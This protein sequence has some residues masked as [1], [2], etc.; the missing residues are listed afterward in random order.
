MA[1]SAVCIV[2]VG[3]CSNLNSEDAN[4]FSKMLTAGIKSWDHLANANANTQLHQLLAGN[5]SEQMCNK[6]GD[7]LLEWPGSDQLTI[8]ALLNPSLRTLAEQLATIQPRHPNR[9]IVY[10]GPLSNSSGWQ[11]RDAFVTPGR[12]AHLAG[13]S[14]SIA[15]S[16]NLSIFE[17]ENS[18]EQMLAQFSSSLIDRTVAIS[19]DASNGSMKM[20]PP[21]DASAAGS[22]DCSNRPAVY[23]F[24]EAE[25]PSLCLCVDGYCLV[26]GLGVSNSPSAWRFLAWLVR[27]DALLLTNWSESAGLGALLGHLAGCGG[28]GPKLQ[29]CL[30]PG[31]PPASSA[32]VYDLMRSFNGGN[33]LH[34]QEALS[35]L[36]AKKP[37]E[38]LILYSMVGRGCLNLYCFPVAEQQQ[39]QKTKPAV[40]KSK[41]SAANAANSFISLLVWQPAAKQADTAA[42]WSR[43]LLPGAATDS[44]VLQALDRGDAKSMDCLRSPVYTGPQAAAAAAAPTSKKTSTAPAAASAA[45]K[46][47]I[48]SKAKPTAAAPAVKA[49]AASS[50]SKPT[51]AVASKSSKSPSPAPAATQASTGA[52]KKAPAAASTAKRGVVAPAAAASKPVAKPTAKSAPAVKLAPTKSA[53]TNAAAKPTTAVSRPPAK[54]A[55]TVAAKAPA[56][57]EPKKATS[58]APKAKAEPA[59][60]KAAKAPVKA[61]ETASAPSAA[62]AAATAAKKKAPAKKPPAEVEPVPK[63]EDIVTDKPQDTTDLTDVVEQ[64]TQDIVEVSQEEQ[65]SR[66]IVEAG[67]EEEQ[68]S[69]EILK[70]A[71]VEEQKSHEIPEATDEEDQKSQIFEAADEEDQKSHEILEAA[72][73]E[74][75]KS[76]EILEAA[77][78]EDQK[79]HDIVEADDDEE[80]KSQELADDYNDEKLESNDI[81]ESDEQV[82]KDFTG[83][84][85]A[86]ENH[87][88]N[89]VAQMA[90]DVNEDENLNPNNQ[91]L[92]GLHD[93]SH[94]GLGEFEKDH[95]P[96]IFGN[97]NQKPQDMFGGDAGTPQDVFG[98]ESQKPQ[99]MFG[100]ETQKPQ[101]MFG[102]ESQKPQDM[103][104]DETQKPQDMFGDESQKPQDMFGDESQKPQDMFG[105]ESQTAHVF[106][107]GGNGKNYS[108]AIQTMRPRYHSSQSG[109]GASASDDPVDDDD[110]IGTEEVDNI[111][112]RGPGN[113]MQQQPLEP[114]PKLDTDYLPG[115]DD[116]HRLSAMEDAEA[117]RPVSGEYGFA[118]DSDDNNDDDNDSVKLAPPAIIGKS[119]LDSVDEFGNNDTSGGSLPMPGSANGNGTSS[120]LSDSVLQANAEADSTA[121]VGDDD[122]AGVGMTDSFYRHGNGGAGDL[123]QL[124][125]QPQI[126]PI[127]GWDQPLDFQLRHR[128]PRRSDRHLHR[129]IRPHQP[130]RFIGS[131]WP[132][133]PAAASLTASM[134]NFSDAFELVTTLWLAASRIPAC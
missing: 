47:S 6:S 128:P 40:A 106:S 13:D 98:D 35:S 107:N 11:L 37:T 32:A 50:S 124:Q 112:W 102:D 20:R 31:K 89:D 115:N 72:D 123:D 101:E 92:I 9:R 80:Q 22:I 42:A 114:S 131:T 38:P 46:S 118:R 73:E 116:G 108:D 88:E 3:P 44:Q 75:Q 16:N 57:P 43:V 86:H 51:S 39:Q 71:D 4:H 54:T 133:F 87:P 93:Q 10:A 67:N 45:K 125:Q 69:H 5:P 33:G 29:A 103:F 18:D 64:T 127:S 15:A 119:T 2:V 120:Y 76:H 52:V 122:L 23:L 61:K 105:D 21:A 110:Q 97:G 79:S 24:P 26:S 129:Q 91:Q 121:G 68:K 28:G 96:N 132:T 70:A 17:E 55:P 83:T 77:D 66:D 94:E 65:K 56:K 7:I 82:S 8:L 85:D 90:Q 30:I 1:S 14:A 36:S 63:A 117:V 104:G 134:L 95:S 84:N 81:T 53:A 12:L 113:A 99:D 48:V 109:D 60:P 25:C 62:A 78:E 27:I 49:P 74:D 59:V 41:D 100:D 130:V 19:N 111:V 126:D 58:P 34:V